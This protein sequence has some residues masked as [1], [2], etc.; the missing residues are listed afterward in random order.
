MPDGQRF[1]LVPLLVLGLILAPWSALRAAGA[2]LE[3]GY[4]SLFDGR[5]LAGWSARNPDYW[6]VEGGV[7]TG[8]ITRERSCATNQYLAWAGGDLADFELKLEARLEGEGGIN[9]GF[10]F[11]SRL[12]P[13]HDVCG[14]QVDNNLRT[15]WLV[16]LYDEYGRH[17]LALRG[18]R[19][20]FD[21]QGRRRVEPLAEARGPAW[22]QLENWH[23]YHLTC[24]GPRIALRV[25]GRLVAEVE[26]G[27]PRRAEAQGILALQLHSGP[28]SVAQFRN[29][30]LK[31]LKPAAT[32]SAPDWRTNDLRRPVFQDALAWWRLDAGG[33]GARPPLRLVPE[34]YRFELNVRAAGEGTDAVRKV[35]LLAGA[36]FDAG[37]ELHA[38]GDQLTVHLRARD[39]AGKWN[40]ALMAKR[41]GPDRVHFNLFSTD[42]PGTVGPDIGFEIRTEAGFVMV[43]FPVTNIAATAWHDLVGRYDGRELVLFCDGRRMAA[44]PAR[45]ALVRNTEPLLLGAETDGDRVVRHFQGELDEA[46]IWPRALRDEEVAALGLPAKPS[47]GSRPDGSQRRDRQ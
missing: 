24:I 6:S 32:N 21:A 20:V 26:D 3:A 16:R 34:F 25:N 29:I 22:F 47:P 39:P 46:A 7:F 41:G 45:G 33:H 43:S 36:Y 1:P 13:D 44:R 37:R 10:Q 15:A 12:L 31:V 17:D 4:Q 30:R 35:A 18:E 8:R 23:E 27:D 40:S 5:S 28:P 42:L 38:P 9:G 11:R 2:G 14:Y 19:A